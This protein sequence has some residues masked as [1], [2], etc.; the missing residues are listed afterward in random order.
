MA[1]AE[2]NFTIGQLVYAKITGYPAWPSCIIE[3]KRVGGR[4]K[5]VVR[6]FNWNSDM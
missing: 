2:R 1:L 5:A 3:L 4:D 6:Y